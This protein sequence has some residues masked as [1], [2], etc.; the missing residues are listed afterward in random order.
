MRLRNRRKKLN[1]EQQKASP[2]ARKNNMH[3]K[4]GRD[5]GILGGGVVCAECVHVYV[6]G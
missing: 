5:W 4:G 6:H 2:E 3:H 1:D